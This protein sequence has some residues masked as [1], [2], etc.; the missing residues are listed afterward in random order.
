M[1]NFSDAEHSQRPLSYLSQQKEIL[2]TAQE[3]RL[4][5]ALTAIL[6][7]IE[8]S[9]QFWNIMDGLVSLSPRLNGCSFLDTSFI[10]FFEESIL[11]PLC[12]FNAS[13]IFVSSFVCFAASF[14]AAF[15]S[16]SCVCCSA[17]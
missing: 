12:I 4:L 17:I 16:T 6:P 7:Q 5:N 9:L 2:A 1:R 3:V 14:G 15:L 13:F 11:S 8:G 10:F